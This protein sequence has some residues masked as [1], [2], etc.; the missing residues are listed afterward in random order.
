MTAILLTQ[1]QANPLDPRPH[2]V[3][4]K[5]AA[6]RVWN[7][8]GPASL[9]LVRRLLAE[10]LSPELCREARQDPVT[11]ALNKRADRDATA[12]ALARRVAG[13]RV[14][15][16]RADLDNFK[17]LND[18]RGHSAGDAALCVV[19]EALERATRDVDLVSLARPGGDEFGLTL[20]VAVDADSQ[21]I[22]DRIERTVNGALAAA[23][24]Q[25]AN[26]KQIGISIG[27]AEATGPTTPEALDEAADAAARER[28]QERRVSQPRIMAAARRTVRRPSER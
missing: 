5:R 24:L 21:A 23:G 22:R 16:L 28:K 26:G 20:S 11:G 7:L 17:A 4:G 27:V 6:W 12:R 25:E 8:L 2:L 13:S 9:Q 3:H 15:R 10:R 14:V 19:R 18:V 1:N